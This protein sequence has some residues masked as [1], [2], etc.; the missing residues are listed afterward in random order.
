LTF[1]LN[2]NK[3]YVNRN[4]N[5]YDLLFNTNEPDN[6]YVDSFIEYFN[7]FKQSDVSNNTGI[8]LSG[9]SDSRTVL[10][11]LMYTGKYFETYSWGGS[12][13]LETY[14]IKKLAD[15]LSLKNTLIEYEELAAYYD[16]YLAQG[17]FLTNGM[18]TAVHQYYYYTKLPENINLFEGY[19]GSEFVKGEL[20]DGMI[21]QVYY[22]IVKNNLTLTESLDKHLGDL[23]GDMK[24]RMS[25]YIGNTFG[26]SFENVDTD[27]GK[28]KFQEYLIEFIPSRVFSGIIN[29]GIALG[30]NYYLPFFSPEILRKLFN[31]G[32]GIKN[33]ISLRKDF[34]GTEK[35]IEV[36]SKIVKKINPDIFSS[37]LDRNVKFSEYNLPLFISGNLRKYRNYKDKQKIKKL[38]VTEQVDYKNIAK[39]SDFNKMEINNY[40]K[41]TFKIQNCD[42]KY[43]RYVSLYLNI[44]DNILQNNFNNLFE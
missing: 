22:D 41:D 43:I 38:P 31:A 13:Y 7:N 2:E 6:N 36:Q 40:I 19:L 5:P 23:G 20:S 30:V 3:I 15:K 42:N 17:V 21:K 11:G 33:N 14:K 29:H 4:N 44:M 18:L 25:E 32:Y 12:E 1:D 35:I 24:K 28:R 10:S 39:N 37:L 34:P 16:K 27:T 26:D 8:S 9:G